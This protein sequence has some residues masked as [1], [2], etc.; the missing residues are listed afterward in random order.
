[1]RRVLLGDALVTAGAL[2]ILVVALVSIDVRVREH[3]TRI[4][5]AGPSSGMTAVM[6]QGREFGSVLM[7]TVR[8]QGLDQPSIVVFVMAAAVLVVVMLR[9]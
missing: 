5:E 4:L 7:S 1:M 3:A 2:A 6:A 9:T 8:S